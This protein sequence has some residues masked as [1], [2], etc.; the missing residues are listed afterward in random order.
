MKI[1][2][3]VESLQYSDRPQIAIAEITQD[4]FDRARRLF[5][6]IRQVSR[7][8][9]AHSLLVE[10]HTARFFF[11]P[12]HAVEALVGL[13]KAESLDKFSWVRLSEDFDLETASA[14]LPSN[15]FTPIAVSE[16]FLVIGREGLALKG[17]D[18]NGNE[19]RSTSLD[20]DE[21]TGSFSKS[22]GT[23]S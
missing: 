4:Q 5:S 2:V 23:A 13:A 19:Y 6:I 20:P 16:R 15:W 9:E 21:L 12:P 18:S 14:G 22:V 11:V 10:T 17:T 7:G 8:F 3:R 1:L